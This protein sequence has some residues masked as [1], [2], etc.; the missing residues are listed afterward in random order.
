MG[1]TYTRVADRQRSRARGATI[2]TGEWLLMLTSAVMLLAVFA[3][4][5]G[6]VAAETVRAADAAPPLNL[7]A[8]A[9]TTPDKLE[10]PLAAVFSDPRE[11]KAAAR[12]LSAQFSA[13]HAPGASDGDLPNV[14]A[15][16]RIVTAGRP[17]L[18]SAQL[19]ILKPLVAVRTMDQFRSSVLWCA[20]A[21]ILSFQIVS[22][23]WRIRS[24]DGDRVLLALAHLL[25]TVG[26]L[27]MLSRPDPLRDTLLLIRYTEGIVIGV[28]LFG[29]VSMINFDRTRFPELTYVPLVLAL[30]LSVVLLV[31]GSGPGT[32]QARINLGPVQPIE[33]IRLLLALFLAGY[34]ARRWE[35]LRQLRTETVRDRQVPG[36]INLPRLEHVRPVVTGVALALVLFFF[37][38]DLGPAL[39][40]ALMFLSLFAIARGG[41]WL[42][43]A[44]LAGLV[45]GFAL[46]Y[47]L[48]ISAT[49]GTRLAMW[50]SPWDNAVRGGDQVAQ[51]LW[52]MA[53]G[54][55]GGTGV[56]LGSPRFVPEAHT[57]LVLAAVGEELGLAGLV[58]VGLAFA[59]M[60]WRGFDIAKRASTDYRFFLASALTLSLSIPVL[61]MAAGILG[62]LPLTGVVTPFMSYG[63]SAMVANFVAL[64]LL[65]ALGRRSHAAADFAPFAVPVRWLSGGMAACA[66]VML[67]VCT[68]VQALRADEYLV[69]PQMSVQA[70]GGRRFQ[71]NPR[72]LEAL[73]AIPRGTIYD[74]RGLPLASSDSAV[75]AKAAA[76]YAKMGRKTAE[77][78]ANPNSRCYPAGP[79]MFH[80]LGDVN[81]RS[82]WS[83]A[84]SSY[85]ER[86]AEDALR[87]FDDRAA[88]VSTT[89]AAG[90][91]S[92][93]VRRDYSSVVSL[94]RHRW[95]P[96]HPDVKTILTRNRDIRVSI[97][98]RLQLAVAG[99]LERA[100]KTAG[101]GQGAAVVLDADTGRILASVSYPWP[102]AVTADTDT[103]VFL[104]RARY[105]LYPPG[106]TF[107]MITAAAALREDPA[108]SD[109]AFVCQRLTPTR[110]GAKIPGFG[111][112]V[113]DDAHDKNPHGT[114]AMHDAIVKS[115]NAYFAQLAIALGSEPL[116]RTAAAAGITLNS[117][118]SSERIK[119]NLPHAGYG[120]GEVVATPLRIARVAAAIGTDGTLREAP[121]VTGGPAIETAFLTPA[122]AHTLS[123]GLRDAVVLGTGRLLKD[124]PARIA[125]KTGTA[126]VDEAASHAWFAGFA[127]QGQATRRIAFAV[128]LEHAGYGGV[129][130]A[131]VAGQIATAA[132]SLGFI[133]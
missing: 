18:T 8:D 5:Q 28:V 9:D 77:A 11:R 66:G 48:N 63:G 82:N 126:E 125:G 113:Y 6:R 100:A 74:S 88:T 60:T 95:E 56:G 81:S 22:L 2:T 41:A 45:G 98:T 21:T 104:D 64:G 72:V 75:I 122:A 123:A 51:G 3:G 117:S 132:Q 120:Q 46:G 15:L 84:N 35:H 119:A 101:T 129:A 111:P 130:A 115:C 131:N 86:D 92:L 57:D 39:L 70:D 44:G 14:G 29:A 40:I 67:I 83:A 99:I 42:A 26:F 24:V 27:V 12:T 97:D 118:K 33:A 90:Q 85:L 54:A 116:A 71:Y 106:S 59:L 7:N 17:L 108:A 19:A 20:L 103:D 89:D 78:C 128:V 61:I 36:W 43:G 23:L 4:Y 79:G 73:R 1:V 114:L 76:D 91:P 52:G 109:R 94:V 107:K 32:S 87:G 62:L 30:G 102:G 55:I 93:A 96:E 80:V 105:G 16:T 65:S 37:Q 121:L 49:L 13:R 47:V 50:Q 34:F 58:I 69:R 112:P 110:V 53:A 38:K 31:F 124:H 127:P 25:V 133:K 10:G 68:N